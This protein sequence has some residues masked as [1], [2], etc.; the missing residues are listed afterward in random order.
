LAI[1]GN[2]SGL[3][4]PGRRGAGPMPH[5]GHTVL[6]NRSKPHE[7]HP[8]GSAIV[9]FTCRGMRPQPSECRHHRR[10]HGAKVGQ[11][12][13]QDNLYREIDSIAGW[14]RRYR[15]RQL[16]TADRYSDEQRAVPGLGWTS[17]L[18]RYLWKLAHGERGGSPNTIIVTFHRDASLHRIARCAYRCPSNIRRGSGMPRKA[19]SRT[20][21]PSRPAATPNT[22][23]RSVEEIWASFRSERAA[24]TKNGWKR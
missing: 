8:S 4:G 11:P 22:K 10:A 23:P 16:H 6:S 5:V 17:G 24:A 12:E 15:R 21:G 19:C 14:Q 2:D 18:T 9:P 13:R 1:C 20:G 3:Q 7:K